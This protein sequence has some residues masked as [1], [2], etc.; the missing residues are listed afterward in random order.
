MILL[1]AAGSL[2]AQ[3]HRATRL[4]NPATRFAPYVSTPED[5]RSRFSSLTLRPD[6]ASIL[7]QWDWRGDMDDLFRAAATAEITEVK[8]PSGTRMPFMSS[9]E[10]GK[11]VMLRDVLWAGEE[12]ISA[13][14]FDFVSKGRFYRCVT[15]RLCS[16]FFLED[17]GAPS[18]AIDCTAPGEIPV[19]RDVLLCMTVRNT[20]SA[21][22]PGTTISVPIPPGA[23]LT[24]ISAGAV[25]AG[26]KVSWEVPDLA[27]NKHKQVCAAFTMPHPGSMPFVATAAGTVA[28][29]VQTACESRVIGIPALLIDAVDLQDPVET[30]SNVTYNIEVTNQGS[31]PC[32]DLRL[33][34]TLPEA[35]EFVS[36]SGA[37][38]VEA[39]GRLV[40]TV[41]L[42]SVPPKAVVS[43]RVI[44]KALKP[45]DVRFKVNLFAREFDRPIFEEES[46]RQY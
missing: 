46:T 5:L 25:S 8:L 22:E 32:T 29:A 27:P 21:A 26:G 24:A 2:P 15:P 34:C 33:E 18:L 37:S 31:I 40:K 38:G 19:G 1:L 6:I 39:E 12:P 43:W 45:G 10:G 7:R 4:G 44:V 23:V 9:R 3:Q 36:G 35:Q 14:S 11:P 28:P 17:L 42:A 20:G 13:Y 41:P 16:N 30:G